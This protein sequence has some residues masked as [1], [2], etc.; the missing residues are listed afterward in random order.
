MT[1]F[2]FI[3]LRL[4]NVKTFTY[5]YDEFLSNF[6]QLTA[7]EAEVQ[8]RDISNKELTVYYQAVGNNEYSIIGV[9]PE[10]NVEDVKS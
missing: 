7:E 3:P 5:T 2:N 8:L 1:D 10:G 4:T 6:I 9:M